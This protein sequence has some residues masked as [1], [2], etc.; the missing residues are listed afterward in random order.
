LGGFKN[1]DSEFPL[2]NF[3]KGNMFT[4]DKGGFGGKMETDEEKKF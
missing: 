1:N 4:K 3:G 2:K